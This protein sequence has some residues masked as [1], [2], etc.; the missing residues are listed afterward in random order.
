VKNILHNIFSFL[1]IFSILIAVFYKYPD[2]SKV[3]FK[4]QI[5]AFT[6][7]EDSR[8]INKVFF[9]FEF[10]LLNYWENKEIS[11]TALKKIYE[12]Y[13]ERFEYS[14]NEIQKIDKINDS[15][16]VLTTKYIFS[17]NTGNLNSYRLSETKFRFNKSGKI[18]SITNLSLQ[19]I[20]QQFIIDN[21]L[22]SNFSYTENIHQ[23]NNVQLVPFFGFLLI[24]NLSVQ[25]IGS[26]N[27]NEAENGKI[28]EYKVNNALV[29]NDEKELHRLIQQEELEKK[30]QKEL[31]EK[32]AAKRALLIRLA[33][34][35]I[36][37][38][39]I[40]E[41][42]KE[43]ARIERNKIAKEKREEKKRLEL[44]QKANEEAK[45]KIEKLVIKEREEKERKKREKEEQEKLNSDV[46]L[47]DENEDAFFDDNLS[48]YITVIADDEEVDETQSDEGDFLTDK[49]MTQDLRNKLKNK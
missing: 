2:K 10:P 43:A 6:K 30:K 31:K 39:K 1:L 46:A 29:T 47:I 20:N 17:K 7:A 16:F 3:D 33:K 23:K 15:E 25:L 8:D 4:K 34:E 40:E 42:K 9:Y 13:W 45:I 24:L 5:V 48:Q 22:M 19:K 11:K 38:E 32:E 36:A 18:T 35:K 41:V 28:K 26:K 27:K 21:N 12:S 49:Y 37:K 44:I 14:E